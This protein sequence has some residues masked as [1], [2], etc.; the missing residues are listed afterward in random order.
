M[1]YCGDERIEQVRKIFLVI[2]VTVNYLLS[3]IFY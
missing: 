2:F 3:D 1:N